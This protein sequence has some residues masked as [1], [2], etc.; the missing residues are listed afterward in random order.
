MGLLEQSEGRGPLPGEPN[1]GVGKSHSP[2]V[3][4]ETPPQTLFWYPKTLR[5]VSRAKRV[6]NTTL[7]TVQV[8]RL[9]QHF[10]QMRRT[11]AAGFNSEVNPQTP[12][13]PIEDA[14]FFSNLNGHFAEKERYR[15][16]ELMDEYKK[17][18]CEQQNCLGT[19]GSDY[20]FV[21]ED[22]DP[23]PCRE[24]P[25]KPEFDPD[26]IAGSDGAAVE[27][28]IEAV[29]D[30]E[31][32]APPMKVS[33][34]RPGTTTSEDVPREEEDEVSA[35]IAD[36]RV[37]AGIA[38]ASSS[39]SLPVSAE[40]SMEAIEEIKAESKTVP[41]RTLI[42][43]TSDK[44]QLASTYR[45]SA[46]ETPG[47]SDMLASEGKEAVLANCTEDGTESAADLDGKEALAE[48]AA[49]DE[50]VALDLSLA[51]MNAQ[52]LPGRPERSSKTPKKVMSSL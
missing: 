52:A 5:H 49:A 9:C 50:A 31:T 45:D 15:V 22:L 16:V 36:E 17:R 8:G 41:A 4:V 11:P 51:Q 23:C 21:P 42:R 1:N 32:E 29:A 3:T 44:M 18:L 34:A 38:V 24:K 14:C 48:D 43:P 46:S 33:P 6:S 39:G 30:L 27:A 10:G 35:V 47:D 2:E 19:V 20:V 40:P 25:K 13:D 37:G 7:P 26:S 12:F 28:Q